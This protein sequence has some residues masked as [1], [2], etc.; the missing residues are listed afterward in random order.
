MW[1]TTQNSSEKKSLPFDESCGQIK[2]GPITDMYCE[3]YL[4]ENGPFKGTADLQK[5]INAIA[6]EIEDSI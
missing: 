1:K 5:M 4:E 3:E 6:A 2:V